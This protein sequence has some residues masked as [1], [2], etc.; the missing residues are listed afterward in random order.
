MSPT[1]QYTQL[2]YSNS[3]STNTIGFLEYHLL[4]T[5]LFN[6][7]FNLVNFLLDIRKM[8]QYGSQLQTH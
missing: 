1:L 6:N 7:K 4:L 5:N 2:T 8:V 3:A